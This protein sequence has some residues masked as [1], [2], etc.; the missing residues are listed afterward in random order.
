MVSK[1]FTVFFQVLWATKLRCSCFP[2]NPTD[3]LKRSPSI[4]G[5]EV[6]L[7]AKRQESLGSIGRDAWRKQQTKASAAF[8]SRFWGFWPL[9][10]MYIIYIYIYSIYSYEYAL[11]FDVIVTFLGDGKA[12]FGTACW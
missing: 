1:G 11:D 10:N 7:S 9:P 4:P 6:R 2:L 12:H 8:S 5:A 3:R